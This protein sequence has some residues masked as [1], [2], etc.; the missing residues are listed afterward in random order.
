[1][2]QGTRTRA[3]LDQAELK[4]LTG[5]VTMPPL[6]AEQPALRRTELSRFMSTEA[7]GIRPTCFLMFGPGVEIRRVKMVREER[8]AALHELTAPA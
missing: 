6:A 2:R 5:Y 3:L 4:R 8:R 7:R 1:M